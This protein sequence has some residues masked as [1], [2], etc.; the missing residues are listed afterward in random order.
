METYTTVGTGGFGLG[1]GAMRVKASMVRTSGLSVQPN[2]QDKPNKP[3]KREVRSS[4]VR[5]DGG[6][7]VRDRMGRR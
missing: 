6:G 2:K 4:G 5:E 3:I 7:R 1:Y